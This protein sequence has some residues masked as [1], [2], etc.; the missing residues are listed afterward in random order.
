M[1]YRICGGKRLCGS[2]R[3]Q[4]SKNAALPI[5]AA[6]LLGRGCIILHNCPKILDVYAMLSILRQLGCQVKWE[7]HT[8]IICTEGLFSCKVPEKYA[9]AM[10]SSVMLL[11]PLLGR[12]GCAEIAWPGGCLIGARPVDIHQ[13]ALEK[14]GVRFD[15]SEKSIFAERKQL[16]GAVIHLPFPS[17]GATENVI[18][19]AVLAVGTTLIENAAKE[20]E[21]TALC[22][23]LRSMGAQISG[24]GGSRIVIEG[25]TMLSGTEFMIPSD[26]I[27]MGT[28]LT[29]VL[30]TGGDVFLEGSCG[31]SLGILLPLARAA[32]ADIHS[33]EQGFR[34]WMKEPFSSTARI[35]TAPY[36]GFPTDLQSPFLALLS[37]SGHVCSIEET[38]FESRFGTAAELE[39]MG[40]DIR[41]RGQKAWIYGKRRLKGARVKASDLRGGAALVLA[42]LFA[43][44]ETRVCET[45]HIRRGYQQ[46][47]GD[48]S[49]LGAEIEEVE[50]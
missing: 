47:T 6:V 2:V 7:E 12:I 17:V 41:I 22:D 48:L 8:V 28:Y 13:T 37:A 32:G 35:T 29:A 23:F 38:V 49:E 46:M 15:V 16:H 43:E 5:L 27:V 44:G 33:C 26:R 36:P 19:A 40:A 30:G 25:V 42:G 45:G 4:G 11:G 10:R 14:M 50:M 21:I 3:I 31:D 18:M 1:A 9:S 39:K 34:V 20:P 24:D